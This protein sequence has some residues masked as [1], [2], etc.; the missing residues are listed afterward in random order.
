M[1]GL[2]TRDNLSDLQVL[3]YL[4]SETMKRHSLAWKRDP[5]LVSRWAEG[6]L[7]AEPLP[8]YPRPQMV[9]DEWLSLNGEWDFQGD[10][11]RKRGIVHPCYDCIRS[12]RESYDAP[13]AG[14]APTR[15]RGSATSAMNSFVVK[16]L[17]LAQ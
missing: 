8:E 11:P 13:A 4:P 17:C 7:L 1:A 12:L 9:R 5:K 14:C 2:R 15:Q 6:L 16:S 3:A 10:G